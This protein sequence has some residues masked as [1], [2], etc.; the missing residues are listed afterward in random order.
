MVIP[1][2]WMWEANHPL[3]D[4][5]VRSRIEAVV[6]FLAIES[7]AARAQGWQRR[8]GNQP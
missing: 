7:R 5:T 8:G 1:L 2:R 3:R 4:A 6:R